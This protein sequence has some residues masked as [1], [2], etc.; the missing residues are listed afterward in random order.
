MSFL[1]P[2]G[3]CSVK[4]KPGKSLAMSYEDLWKFS[5][6]LS[7]AQ[8]YTVFL[9]FRVIAVGYIDRKVSGFR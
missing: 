8:N 7:S 9:H 1:D 6:L 4:K 5:Y 3:F 2:V